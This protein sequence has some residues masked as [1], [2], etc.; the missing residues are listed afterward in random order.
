MGAWQIT[1]YQYQL[2]TCMILFMWHLWWFRGPRNLWAG[3]L[4]HWGLDKMADIFQT[5]FSNAFSWMKMLPIKMSLTFVP[6]GPINNIPALVQIM[7]WRLPGDKPWSGPMVVRLPTHIGVT[8][9]QW[10]NREGTNWNLWFQ[11]TSYLTGDG[12]TNKSLGALSRQ[13]HHKTLWLYFSNS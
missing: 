1:I 3:P 6:H 11:N 10:V 7:G 2:Y 12:K 9:P 13:F 8:R 5:T 4:T